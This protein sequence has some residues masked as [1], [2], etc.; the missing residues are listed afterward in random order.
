VYAP[1]ISVKL[2]I[3][4]DSSKLTPGGMDVASAKDAM[5]AHATSPTLDYELKAKGITVD[6]VTIRKPPPPP[7]PPPL[8]QSPPPLLAA[9]PPSS[10][11][12]PPK[13]VADYD[14][15]T[16]SNYNSGGA[17]GCLVAAFITLSFVFSSSP[18]HSA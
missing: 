18:V 2:I 12:P 13:F 10:P 11:L 9:P 4:I 3:T 1:K 14:S 17:F 5:I 16:R 7:L 15:S 6:E 8:L